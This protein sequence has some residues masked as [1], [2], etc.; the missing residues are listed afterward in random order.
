M[1]SMIAVA[2]HVLVEVTLILRVM[3]RSHRDPA[4]RIAW[5]AVIGTVPVVGILGYLLL[6]EVNIGR[7]RVAR[8]RKVLASLPS[9]AVAVSTD[10][11]NLAPALPEKYQSLFHLGE[12]I[13]GFPPVGGNS[14]RLMPDSNAAIEAM[15]A[16][17]DAATEHVHLL[18][19]IWLTDHNGRKMVDALKRAAGRGVVCRAM[20]DGLGS[21]GMIRSQHWQ[22]MRN[23]GVHLGVALPIGNPLL[24]SMV[25]RIDLRNHRKILVIDGQVTYCGSQNCADPEFLVKARYAPWV[26]AVMRFEGPVARQ[27]LQLFASDWMTYT[28]EDLGDLLRQ[29]MAAPQSGFTA[30]VIG[31]GPTQR[32]SAMP[33]TFELLCYCAQRELVISTPYYV[34]DDA[35]QNAIRSAAFR[36]VKTTIIFPE[37]ND[38]WIVAGA[39]RSYYAELLEAGVTIYEYRGGLLHTKSLTLDD[40]ITLI[41]SANMDRRSFELNYENNILFYDRDL[42]AAMRKRQQHYIE[43]S[44]LISREAVQAWSIPRRVWNNALAVLGPVL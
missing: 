35:M 19:Y 44:T 23:A 32:Y 25:S 12:S 7:R 13:S 38:S 42:T 40:E 14:A 9:V 24:R 3:L 28:D 33:E 6:G 17:I 10:Q 5:V 27:N 41:G 16:D 8:L 31:T 39:S 15:V 29:P 4:S 2:I 43:N 37:R 18:F 30:Q 26:D 34:P 1:G 22:A 20:V 36:G 11:A 21:R